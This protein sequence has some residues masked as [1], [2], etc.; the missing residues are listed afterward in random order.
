MVIR[1]P[2]EGLGRG[3][4]SRRGGIE[5]KGVVCSGGTDRQMIF[6]IVTVV[7]AGGP[8]LHSHDGRW[9][10]CRQRPFLLQLSWEFGGV[11]VVQADV[12]GWRVEVGK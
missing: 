7:R 1:G 2:P 6:E 12:V 9:R 4:L 10:F 3:S 11:L 5:T 8:P